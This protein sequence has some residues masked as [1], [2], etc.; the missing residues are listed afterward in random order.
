MLVG[1][2]YGCSGEWA[3]ELL[4]IYNMLTGLAVTA[5]HKTGSVGCCCGFSSHWV[6]HSPTSVLGDG[7]SKCQNQIK[8]ASVQSPFLGLNFP[9]AMEEQ[10]VLSRWKL[11][12]ELWARHR[13]WRA[14][15]SNTLA[16]SSLGSL[17]KNHLDIKKNHLDIKIELDKS[18]VDLP[19]L[20]RPEKKSSTKSTF[21]MNL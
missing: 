21:I 15:M 14:E 8:C 13:W 7:A 2:S 3:N 20:H 16:C 1:V 4:V 9:N 6:R 19:H 10:H 17:K 11:G 12:P 5:Q 18:Q